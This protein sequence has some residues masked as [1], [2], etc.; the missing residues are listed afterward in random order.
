MIEGNMMRIWKRNR[1]QSIKVFGFVTLLWFGLGWG[2]GYGQVKEPVRYVGS[3]QSD[4]YY[5]DGRLPHAVGVH[6]IQVFRANRR[7]PIE[8]GEIGFTYNH[9]PYLAYW[10]GQFYLQFLSGKIQEHTPPTRIMLT[11]SKDGYRWSNPVILFPEYELPEINYQGYTIPAGTKA[12]MHQRMGFYVAP[13]GR[14][15]AL[16]FYSFCPTPRFSPNKGQGLGRVVRE[17][18]PDGSFGPIYFIRYNRHVGWNEKNTHYPFYKTSKDKGFVQV[19]EALLAN[20]LMILQWWEEDRSNDGF[21]PI[22][23]SIV[24]QSVEALKAGVTTSAGAGKAFCFYHLDDGQVVGLWKNGYMATSPDDG[25]TWSPIV[26]S[27]TLWTCGAKIWAQRTDDGR[28]AL[29]YNHSATRRNR[30]PLTIMTSTNGHNF[31]NLMVVQGEVPPMRYQGIHKNPGPQYVRGIVEG[32]GNPP[33]KDMWITYSMNK[34]DIWVSRIQVPVTDAVSIPVSQN[35]DDLK[36]VQELTY[37]NLYMPLWAPIFLEKESNGNVALVLQDEAPYDY[38][39]AERIF[40]VS[41]HPEVKFRVRLDALKQG[42]ALYVELQDQHGNRPLRLRFDARWLSLD[43]FKVKLQPVP[44]EMKKWYTVTISADCEKEGYDLAINGKWV[45]KEVPFA[46]K[47]EAL[48]RLVFRTGPWRGEVPKWLA[49]QGE[50]K[51]A[52]LYREDLPGG[53]KKVEIS[54]FSIDDVVIH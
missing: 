2:V 27:T 8:G 13:N 34:E 23:F 12:V 10:Q 17:I 26:K 5:Y 36:S 21:Y 50:P 40:P 1:L 44:I 38:V 52:G 28:Y 15:L 35:F 29:V 3:R 7:H 6:S 19:C 41:S 22:D 30:Y 33:G 25:K 24:K 43:H 16:G 32:N 49:E 31:D 42:N 4:P 54:R 46:Q 39:R 51:T 37:W 18:Y 9:Q 11:T 53:E 47:V 14:L 48:Q 20:K 45:K